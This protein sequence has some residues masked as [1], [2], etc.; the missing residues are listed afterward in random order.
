MER[1]KIYRNNASINNFFDFNN[2]DLILFNIIKRNNEK[3]YGDKKIPR[4]GRISSLKFSLGVSG[5]IF[6]SLFHI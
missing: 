1:P 5:R 4:G 6:A 3:A 2:R